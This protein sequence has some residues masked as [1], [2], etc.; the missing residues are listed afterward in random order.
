MLSKNLDMISQ[1]VIA[2]KIYYIRGHKVM[3]DSDLADLY[4]VETKALNQAVKRNIERFPDDFMFQL[5]DEEFENLRSQIVTSSWGGRRTLPYAFTEHGT[6]ML[7]AVLKS[8]RAIDAN[9]LIVRTFVKL[10]E[11]LALNQD[12]AEK[13]QQHDQHIANLYNHLERILKLENTKKNPIG[14]IWDTS[15]NDE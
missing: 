1:D 13:L 8:K 4:Q 12:I 15:N 2:S 3:L 11:I 5:N 6:L 14:Y 10:R 9:I 7:S